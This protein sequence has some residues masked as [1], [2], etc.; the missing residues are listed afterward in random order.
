[1]PIENQSW[2]LRKKPHLFSQLT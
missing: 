2:D 1:M